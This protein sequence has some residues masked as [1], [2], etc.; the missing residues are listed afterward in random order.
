MSKRKQLGFVVL[1]LAV[2]L[3]VGLP[4]ARARSSLAPMPPNVMT[5]QGHLLDAGGDPV[6][7]GTY[8][9]TFELWNAPTEG[10]RLWGA[11]NQDVAVQDGFFSVLLGTVD[12][13][14]PADLDSTTYLGITVEGETLLPRQQLASVAF[15][16]ASSE[17]VQAE[18]ADLL[19]GQTGAYYR[20]WHS[21]TDVPPGFADGIDDDTVYTDTD[22]LEAVSAA[23]FVTST[24]VL[25]V[26]SNTKTITIGVTYAI[27]SSESI[28]STYA[29]VA[30]EV[31]WGDVSGMPAG[32]SDGTD[33]IDDTVSWA[34]VSGIVGTGASQLAG[35]DH[36]HDGRYYTES[37]VDTAL[38]GKS[39]ASHSHAGSDITG[40]VS[41][42]TV[43]LG[44]PWGGLT[45]V[46]AGFADGVD[47]DTTYTAGTGLSLSGTTLSA[48]MG[49]L[50]RRVN[51]CP[52]GSSIREINADG[53]VVCQDAETAVTATYA[54]SSSESIS[55]TYAVVAGEVAWGDVSGMPAGFSDGTDDIDDTVSWAEVSG[56]VGTGASQ[57]AGGDH[58]HDGRYYTESEVDT[59]L[60]GKSDAS[61]SHDSQYYTESELQTSGS[62]SVD[63]GNLASVPAGFSDGTDDVDDTVDWAEVSGIVGTGASQ[64]AGGDHL[65]AGSDITSAVH[66]ATVAL[67]APWSGLTGVPAGFADG[68]DDDN[69][70]FHVSAP[71]ANT[72]SVIRG[73]NADLTMGTDGRGI[74]AFVSK[75]DYP[76]APQHTIRVGH[77]VDADCS[78]LDSSVELDRYPQGQLGRAR[79][80]I[81]QDGFPIIAYTLDE[82]G[83]SLK[84]AHCQNVSCT[85]FTQTTLQADACPT[86]IGIGLDG[87]PSILADKSGGPFTLLH[88]DDIA[89]T[90]ATANDVQVGDEG[91]IQPNMAIGVDGFPLIV[92]EKPAPARGLYTAHCED[93][94]CNTVITNTL[95]LYPDGFMDQGIAIGQ[96]GLPIVIY[97]SSPRSIIRAAHCQDVAC[98]QVTSSTLSIESSSGT[99]PVDVTI[100]ADG[101]PVFVYIVESSSPAPIKVGHCIDRACSTAFIQTL[102]MSHIVAFPSITIGAD[103][104]PLVVYT[105]RRPAGAIDSWVV[106][107]SNP[108]CS[109]YFRR[110]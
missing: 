104:L 103:G 72:M 22:T 94:F 83:G 99:T 27:S 68:V 61:H 41:T 90:S 20:D 92:Y 40:V 21:L 5:Y 60:A 109:N 47:D 13:I 58:L 86:A 35:G 16:L 75:H 67:G 51:P 9:M 18:N 107:C 4:Q 102:G 63:W 77:C 88:C 82:T 62:A 56:I 96:D 8:A 105:K 45:G 15:A 59:A 73:K 25:D 2:V 81:G 32:F 95:N 64:L 80:T 110:Q 55:S 34:E 36:L 91:W 76:T 17:A 26:I 108:F 70:K 97:R 93:V 10:T 100:G 84:V 14:D 24:G 28:S 46:P 54:I 37:E 23:G 44:A 3:S 42:A 30:G 69:G 79:I 31:A 57:L 98:T 7:D 78:A 49:Y 65:H 43:A 89:C 50:Q 12:P 29:V 53:T 101:L 71:Q 38:A 87:L 74:M 6:P 106:H 1:V 52:L 19:E 66:T 85:Q 39:D 48:D 33:D 11:E